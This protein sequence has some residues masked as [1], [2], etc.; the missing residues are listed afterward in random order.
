[1]ARLKTTY[2]K[3]RLNLKTS[4]SNNKS[5]CKLTCKDKIRDVL[6][7]F[8][9]PRDCIVGPWGNWSSC[10][11]SCGG[12]QETRSRKV[13]YPARFGGQACPT[14]VNKRLCNTNPCMNPNFTEKA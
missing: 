12:G 14:L 4:C 11:K 7:R 3:A 1:M 10:T 6:F 2:N 5:T 8:P 13:L 9:R